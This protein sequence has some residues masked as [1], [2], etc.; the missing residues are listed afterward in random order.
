[1][2][3]S[4]TLCTRKCKIY[5]VW[6]WHERYY[7]YINR[8]YIL[9]DKDFYLNNFD[10]KIIS[11]SFVSTQYYLLHQLN[12]HILD[13]DH[14]ESLCDRTSKHVFDLISV[15]N[16]RFPC[17][18]VFWEKRVDAVHTKANSTKLRSLIQYQIPL[19][20]ILIYYWLE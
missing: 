5:W 7:D 9:R 17:C 4:I 1:M 16:Q 10:P 6:K 15:I 18:L 3:P 8:F 12:L 14:I 19:C 13:Y 20:L 2:S 11:K